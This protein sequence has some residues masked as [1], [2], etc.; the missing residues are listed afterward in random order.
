MP[1]SWLIFTFGCS[2]VLND[3]LNAMLLQEGD[4][5]LQTA[6]AD[7]DV[8]SAGNFPESEAVEPCAKRQAC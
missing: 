7:A 4:V 2:R 6:P 8:S 5:C 1:N 3:T